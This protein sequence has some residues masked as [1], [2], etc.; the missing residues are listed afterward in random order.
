MRAS[1]VKEQTGTKQSILSFLLR[2]GI[3][4]PDP[5]DWTKKFINFLGTLKLSRN[6]RKNLDRYLSHL[7]YL[8]TM[9]DELENEIFETSQRER[10]AEMARILLRGGVE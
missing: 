9:L 4:Y 3:K 8:R 2:K 1:Q 7:N 6:D 5:G 10:Y